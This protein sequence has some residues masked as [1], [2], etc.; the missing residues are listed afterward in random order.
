MDTG[1]EQ[2]KQK[3]KD[4]L[5]KGIITFEECAEGLVQLAVSCSHLQ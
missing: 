4:D 3:L 5:V 2:R 1:I